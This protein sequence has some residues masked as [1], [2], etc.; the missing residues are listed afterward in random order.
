MSDLPVTEEVAHDGDVVN[1]DVGPGL[2]RVDHV[3][4]AD[5]DADVM[6]VGGVVPVENQVT[7]LGA[8]YLRSCARAL[9]LVLPPPSTSLP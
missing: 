4:V 6:G 7:G 8:E 1:F 2:E 3:P 9:E 5:V